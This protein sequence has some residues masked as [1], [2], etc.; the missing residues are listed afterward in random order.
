MPKKKSF[1]VLMVIA[2]PVVTASLALSFASFG[3]A[4]SPPI[5]LPKSS[6]S[7]DQAQIFQDFPVYSAGDS[8][9][10]IPLTAVLRRS[11]KANYISFVYGDCFASSDSPCAPPAEV[12]VWPACIRSLALYDPTVPGA[13]TPEP[14]TIRGVP[15]A[16]FEDGSR[17]E[18]HTGRA[19]VVVFSDSRARVLRIASALKGVNVSTPAEVPLPPPAAGA[20]E[21][22][23]A[24]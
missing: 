11:D 22:K 15:A 6:Y 9:D 1:T 5:V 7:L 19:T 20:V 14:V 2:A 24:C 8:A 16:F 10:G 23:L 21:G 17:L 12:Q 4:Q 3:E 18:I 13:P